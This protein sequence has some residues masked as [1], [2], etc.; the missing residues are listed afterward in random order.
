MNLLLDTHVLL[1]CLG[2]PDRLQRETRRK[3]EA[4]ATVIF[5]SAVSA[6]EIE[7]KRSLGKLKVPADLEDQ[8]QEKR[9]TELPVRMRHVHALRS[10]PSLHRD[11]F[12]RMLV[13]QAVADGLV[14][15]TADEKVRAYPVRTLAA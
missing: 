10:L 4:P 9:F 1:W 12:D 11:P 15:V 13:A 5:V 7:M 14:V 2:A 3:I 6:W 8:L